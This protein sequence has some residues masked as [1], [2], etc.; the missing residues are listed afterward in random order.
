MF[1]LIRHGETILP[2]GICIGQKDV[3][4]AEKGITSIMQNTLPKLR[5][6]QLEQPRIIASPLQRTMKTAQIL[7]TE[8][9]VDVTPEPNILEI[10][11]GEWDGLSFNFIKTNWPEA[12]KLRGVDFTHFRPPEGESFFDVQQRALKAVLPL[13]QLTEPVLLVT[14]AGVIR[15]LLCLANQTPLQELF[16]YD[17]APGSITRLRKRVFLETALQLN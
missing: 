12:Y 17:P 3:P 5:A 7:A 10:N 11:M 9:G 8:Y 14:H 4:L 13:C 6:F 1:Y 16:T 15:T 2:K